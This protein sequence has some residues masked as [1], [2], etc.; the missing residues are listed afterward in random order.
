MTVQ[1]PPLVNPNIPQQLVLLATALLEMLKGR[2]NSVSSFTLAA[3]VTTTTVTD[4]LLNSD[5]TILWTP[6]TANAAG[7]MT[8]LYLSGRAA[9]SFTL[10][11]SNTAT[12]DRTFYYVRRG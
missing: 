8:N 12:T 2:D 11:H 4:N 3:N 5:Q 6:T 1:V 7:A 9:G 10:M